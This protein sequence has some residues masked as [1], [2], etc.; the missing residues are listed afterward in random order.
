MSAQERSRAEDAI[1]DLCR[2]LAVLDPSNEEHAAARAAVLRTATWIMGGDQAVEVAQ[3]V[4]AAEVPPVAIPPF[5]V[6]SEVYQNGLQRWLA[7]GKEGQYVAIVN[8]NIIGFFEDAADAWC[9][10]YRLF[11]NVGDGVFVHQV[12]E[13]EPV[14]RLPFI[15]VPLWV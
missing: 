14:L 1:D 9:A 7:E 5:Q 3:A 12:L 13:H 2:V 10:G 6:E 15:V 8:D 4:I 11:P